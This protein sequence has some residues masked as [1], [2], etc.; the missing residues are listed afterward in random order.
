[1]KI[2]ILGKKYKVNER[3]KSLIED[4]IERLSKYFGADATAKVVCVEQ[5]KMKK[6]EVTITNKGLLYR[7]E[8]TSDNMYENI[9]LAL[10]KI[11]RQIVRANEKLKD[12]KKK[13]VKVYDAYEFI[14]ET[15]LPLPD[16]F[17][18]KSFNL[19]PITVDEAK[20]YIDRLGHEFF[21]F[22]NAETGKVNVLYK[23]KDAQFG[24]IEVNY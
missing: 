15:P 10:P 9:D 21:V 23:R 6:M 4:K 24:L 2:E 5:N 18:K 1:M 16:V 14:D 3:L 17:K 20:D 13:A 7:S 11:E 12:K 8:V 22:L 19:D